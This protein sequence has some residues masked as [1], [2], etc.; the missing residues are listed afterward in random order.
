MM[1]AQD[2]AFT[3]LDKDFLKTLDVEVTTN[4][5][6]QVTNDSFVF[7]PFVD[8]YLLLPVFVKDKKPELYIGNEILDDYTTYAQTEDKKKRLE[9]CNK[10]GR[11]FL[12]GVDT[13]KLLDFDLHPHALN[14]MLI[15]PRTTAS[16]S[17]D[18]DNN[19]TSAP[20]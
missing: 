1:F 2:P 9:E 13:V 20:G 12:T 15:Y 4:L 8:W 5:E 3:D 17:D 16:V 10:L 14:G 19:N 7:S 11:S 18:D 6:E